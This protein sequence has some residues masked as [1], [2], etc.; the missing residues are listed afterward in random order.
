MRRKVSYEVETSKIKEPKET[1]PQD[2]QMLRYLSDT[3]IELNS[4]HKYPTVKEIFT[5]LITP[6]PSSTAVEK[7][8]SLAGNVYAPKRTSLRHDVNYID[9][10]KFSNHAF[11]SFFFELCVPEMWS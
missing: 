6:H 2:L 10:N 9:Y 3:S 5:R 7:L 4:L 1:L 8:F 11:Y